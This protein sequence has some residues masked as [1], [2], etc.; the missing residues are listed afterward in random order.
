MRFKRVKNEAN[1]VFKCKRVK[2]EVVRG[3]EVQTTEE[4]SYKSKDFKV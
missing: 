3:F 4:W 2:N 1:M